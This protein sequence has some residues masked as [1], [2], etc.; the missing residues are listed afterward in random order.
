MPGPGSH[1]AYGLGV[2]AAFMHASDG[3]FSHLH[4]L[5]FAMNGWLGP[6]IGSFFEWTLQGH[7]PKL[8]SFIMNFVHHPVGYA[9]TLG[10]PMAMFY[11]RFCNT[12][13]AGAKKSL[14][15]SQSAM[16][17]TAGGFSHFALD[18]PFEE[19]GATDQQKWILSTGWWS[20]KP[21][22]DLKTVTIVGGLS[23]AM[24][25]GFYRISRTPAQKSGRVM[26]GPMKNHLWLAIISGLYMLWCFYCMYITTPR[27]P[28]VGEEADL[29][30]LY[31]VWIY[32]LL[33]LGLCSM[34][35]NMKENG[36]REDSMV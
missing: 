7:N 34:S 17:V 18:I 8:G 24:V 27:V 14:T 19:D 13:L 2:G 31:Y 6:D 15:F 30:V 3:N 21:A 10:V 32:I 1:L 36:N 5:V 29:G 9:L 28:A 35:K 22:M 4:A 12:L 16:L 26:E 20:E 11:K 25:A 33:P 23:L